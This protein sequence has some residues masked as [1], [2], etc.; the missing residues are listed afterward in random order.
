[1]KH[2]LVVDDDPAI[3]RAVTRLLSPYTKTVEAPNAE[4]A[5]RLLDKL[6]FAAVIS[7]FQMPYQNG[8]WLLEQARSKQPNALRVLMSG[9]EP[10]DLAKHQSTG[11]VQQWLSKPFTE[12]NFFACLGIRQSGV[13]TREGP[14][15]S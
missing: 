3:C 1:M 6:T 4:A 9:S 15:P 7:D 11:L 10:P 8:I 2:F 12:E 5:T 14:I 13:A